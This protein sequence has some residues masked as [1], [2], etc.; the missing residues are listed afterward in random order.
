MKTDN[1]TAERIAKFKC[2][3]GKRQSFF[4]DGKTPGLGLRVTAAGAKTYIFEARVRKRSMRL[5]IGDVETYTIVE[6]REK[7]TT[8]KKQTDDGLDPRKVKAEEEAAEET[9]RRKLEGG[10][11]LIDEAW[12]AYIEARKGQWGAAHAESHRYFAN[13]GGQPKKKGG[14]PGEIAPGILRPI[15]NRRMKD[16]TAEI[17]TEWLK[18]EVKRK[19]GTARTC[20][21]LFRTFWLWCDTKPKYKSLIDVRLLDDED[22]LEAIP[23]KRH[24]RFDVLERDYLKP[25][26]EAVRAIAD[27]VRRAFLQALILTGARR[28]EMAALRWVDVDFQWKNLT[29]KD[30]VDEQ[31]RKIPLTPYMHDLLNALPRKS[32]WV[33][34]SDKAARGYIKEPRKSHIGA[35]KAAKL[36]HVS[37]HGLRRTFASLAEWLEMPRGVI[38][39]IMGHKPSATAEQHYIHRP[40]GLLAVW[41]NQYEAWILKE[42][43]VKSSEKAAK[44]RPARKTKS[45]RS[46]PV[47]RLVSSR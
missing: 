25:W 15:L 30:K 20:I 16:L 9:Q 23:P 42:A 21:L 8:L 33:F 41:H 18:T 19:A 37:I 17:L 39:Q 4:R 36:K 45:T 22:L 47:L 26:F 12:T 28:D 35:L 7:A 32:E 38:A 3:P 31:G 43:G 27:P 5:T 29:L 40:L 44:K 14:G 13:I 2:E 34:H 6:A 10:A 11:M 1:F 46:A 24:R